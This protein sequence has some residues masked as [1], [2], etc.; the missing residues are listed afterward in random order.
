VEWYVV[1]AGYVGLVLAGGACLAV[2]MFG[3]ALTGDQLSA[4]LVSFL[5]LVLVWMIGFSASVWSSTYADALEHASLY[6]NLEGLVRGVV[7]TK[8]LVYFAS[9]VGFFLFMCQRLVEAQRDS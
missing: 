7:H 1:G 3:S 6:S 2:G 5:L 9:M 4:A 8:S